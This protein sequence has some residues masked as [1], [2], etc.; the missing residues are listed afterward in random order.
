MLDGERVPK[1]RDLNPMC[2][3]GQLGQAEMSLSS[4]DTDRQPQS[5]LP[6]GHR[7]IEIR[8]NSGRLLD[9]DD[10][11][12]RDVPQIFSAAACPENSN[13]SSTLFDPL[14]TE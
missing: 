7:C 14:R 13:C 10:E 12:E 4:L 5:R 2:S 8:R 6:S 11:R 9:E 3:G 1:L